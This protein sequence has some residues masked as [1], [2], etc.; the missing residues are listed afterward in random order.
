[1]LKDRFEQLR[2][3]H[4]GKAKA[5]VRTA[6]ADP[7]VYDLETLKIHSAKL[8]SSFGRTGWMSCGASAFSTRR[9]AAE[10]F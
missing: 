7:A 9:V 4:E 6:L 1:M 2:Q 8:S 5:T 3:A 10:P